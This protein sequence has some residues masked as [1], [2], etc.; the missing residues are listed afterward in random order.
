GPWAGCPTSAHG[1]RALRTWAAVPLFD[2]LGERHG[3]IRG[4]TGDRR[5]ARRP[6]GA[7]VEPDLIGPAAA[8]GATEGRPLQQARAAR[9]AGAVARSPPPRRR[10]KHPDGTLPAALTIPRAALPR[11]RAP[12]DPRARRSTPARSLTWRLVWTALGALIGVQ[13]P[14]FWGGL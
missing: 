12:F 10:R 4:A 14:L 1:F 13:F 7:M 11:R 9:A 8:P 3:T 2:T 6:G 5:L